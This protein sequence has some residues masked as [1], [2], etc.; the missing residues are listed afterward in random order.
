M[1]TAPKH[2]P[3]PWKAGEARGT[4]VDANGWVVGTMHGEIPQVK[5]RREYMLACVDA[6]DAVGGDPKTVGEL[7]E[8]LR[9]IAKAEGAYNRDPLTHAG[10]TIDSMISLALLADSAIAR[11][12]RI[13]A[14]HV[15]GPQ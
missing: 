7:L 9:E 14:G 11:A 1:S 3:T 13:D 2:S 12:Q 5:E 15:K 8:V 4:F 6:V 10:N